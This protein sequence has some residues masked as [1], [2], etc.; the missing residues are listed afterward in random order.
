MHDGDPYDEV[1][2]LAEVLAATST[3]HLDPPLVGRRLLPLGALEPAVFDRL[4]AE[5]AMRVDGLPYVRVFG[6]SAQEQGGL[7][8][9]AGSASDRTVYQ[10]KRETTLTAA[11]LRSYVERYAGP[12]RRL[13]LTPFPLWRPRRLE[14]RRFVLE[15]AAPDDE[16]VDRELDQLY[17]GDLEIELWRSTVMA[18]V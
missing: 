4:V 7:D 5:V 16:A 6:R 10:V 13:D 2:P 17:A 11:M 9:Y 18:L 1:P 3:Q 12:P 15:V 14:A 8:L